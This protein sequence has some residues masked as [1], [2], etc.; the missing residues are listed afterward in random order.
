MYRTG[1]AN[2]NVRKSGFITIVLPPLEL[3]FFLPLNYPSNVISR[4]TQKTSYLRLSVQ[5]KFDLRTIKGGVITINFV[6]KPFLI[7]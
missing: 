2:P 4:L 1:F 3:T 5:Y 6:I 7:L